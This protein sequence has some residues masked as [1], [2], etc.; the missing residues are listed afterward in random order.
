MSISVFCRGVRDLNS[1]FAK[2]LAL[3]KACDAAN[4]SYPPELQTFFKPAIDQFGSMDVEDKHLKEAMTETDIKYEGNAMYDDGMTIKISDIPS[5][6]KAIR[7]FC[8]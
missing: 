2:M 6:V 8:G 5:D 3:K 4:T 1:K 7:I